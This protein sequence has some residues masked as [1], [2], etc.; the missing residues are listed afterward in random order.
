MDWYQL[1]KLL[2]KGT[3]TEP[4]LDYNPEGVYSTVMIASYCKPMKDKDGNYIG[5]FSTDLSLNWLSETISAVKP[6]PNSYSIMIGRGGTYF[7]HPD[8]KKL[9]Y[10]TIFTET[11]ERP[12]SAVTALGH[13]MLR[14]E[15]GMRQ[16]TFD[17][18]ECYVFYKPLGTT[19]WSVAIVC[20]ESDIFGG[21]NRLLRSVLCI[22]IIG[23]LLMLYVFGQTIK[24]ELTPLH[25]L[26]KQTETIASGNFDQTLPHDGRITISGDVMSG[27]SGKEI[28]DGR[29]G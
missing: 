9:F 27:N 8:P 22:V 6:Y 17:G 16:L 2:D 7:V 28:P 1:C 18:E 21:Y 15:E 14:G 4:F 20:P 19:G 23:L 13:A 12:D 29:S 5:T 24:K 11:M 25:T 26:A 10:Q 3:W